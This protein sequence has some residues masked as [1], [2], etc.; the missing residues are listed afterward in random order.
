MNSNSKE[1][2]EIFWSMDVESMAH[3]FNHIGELMKK[4]SNSYLLS[5]QISQIRKC[6]SLT[7]EGKEIMKIIGEESNEFE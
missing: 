3:F 5:K 4:N 6:S 2:A 1:I 7:N